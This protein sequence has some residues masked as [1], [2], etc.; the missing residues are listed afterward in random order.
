MLERFMN[1]GMEH[2]LSVEDLENIHEC[3]YAVVINDGKIRDFIYEDE[4]A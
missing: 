1:Y 2:D 4:E 3:G